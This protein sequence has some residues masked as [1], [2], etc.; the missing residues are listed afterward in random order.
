MRTQWK[1]TYPVRRVF[2][3]MNRRRRTLPRTLVGP[4][5][6]TSLRGGAVSSSLSRLFSSLTLVCST[7]NLPFISYSICKMARVLS[8]VE[9]VSASV[10]GVL[11]IGLSFEKGNDRLLISKDSITGI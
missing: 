4:L 5:G 8:V 9:G 1:A 7:S 3:R 11:L 6:G 2:S 10:T